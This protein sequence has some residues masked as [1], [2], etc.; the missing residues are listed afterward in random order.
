MSS[1]ESLLAEQAGYYRERAGE[2]EDWWF[3]CGRYD[4]APTPNERWFADAAEVRSA[5]ER[6]PP[7]GD[8]SGK[9]LVGI[10]LWREHA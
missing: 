2:Y 8:V 7:E 4:R 10:T 3:R 9:H 6:F 5:L 1:R